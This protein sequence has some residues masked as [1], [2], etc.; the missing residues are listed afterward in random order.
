MIRTRSDDVV[1]GPSTL[2]V[3]PLSPVAP[4]LMMHREGNL[5]RVTPDV[6]CLQILIVNSC[7]VGPRGQRDSWVLVD[8]GMGPGAA[9]RIRSEAEHCYGPRAH[10]ACLVLTHGHFDHVSGAAELA[11]KWNLLVYAHP[12]ELPYLTGQA[13]YP[14]PDPTVGGGL[15]TRL[16]GMFPRGPIDLGNRVRPLSADGTVPGLPGWKWIHT[17]GHS[18]GHVSLYRAND[19]FLIAGDAFVTTR[20]E[21]ALSAITQHQHLHGPPMYYTP[22]WDSARASVRQLAALRPTVAATGHGIPMHGRD[23][24]RQ[25]QALAADF[26][27]L[28]LPRHGR[29]VDRPALFD[30]QGVVWVPPR[31]LDLR[32]LLAGTAAAV[33][34][35]LLARRIL[36]RRRQASPADAGHRGGR[37][38]IEGYPENPP[39]EAL[40]I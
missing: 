19:G 24:D 29:Y 5:I 34:A 30:R 3:R 14:P 31:P 13:S 25:L 33:A 21:S 16:S 35:G 8:A 40:W 4:Q 27:R 37:G 32:P 22:D 2:D 6:A 39:R 18:P 26:D 9:A 23:L 17:P 12:L 11:R 36:K 10:P 15:M 28:A 38:S 7:F 20:Q 1:A